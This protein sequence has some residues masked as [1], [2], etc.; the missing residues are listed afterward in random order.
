[1][2]RTPES[3]AILGSAGALLTPEKSVGFAA[4]GTL[5][6]NATSVLSP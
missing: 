3:H 1:M 5:F 6:Q 4:N 2:A